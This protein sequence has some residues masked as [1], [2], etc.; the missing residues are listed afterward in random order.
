MT[1]T[2]TTTTTTPTRSNFV[3]RS[4]PFRR[5]SKWAFGVCDKDGD[6]KIEQSELY[7]GILLVH[8]NLA[9]YG[10]AACCYPPAR[11]VVDQL[12]LAADADQSGTID[13]SEFSDI[14][15]ICF[16]DIAG[17][18]VVYYGILILLVPYVADVIVAV[19][20]QLDSWMG[21]QLEGLRENALLRFME[22]FMT[23]KEFADSC[24]SMSLFF[25]VIP[26]LFN[27]IDRH[28]KGHAEKTK[29]P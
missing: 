24:V 10:G 5:L 14:V 20:F 21:W 29:S 17:R 25:F 3:T 16:V 4:A 22:N 15:Q 27:A 9:K 13:E 19:L 12:F 2:A 18:I 6:G 11:E 8:V 1:A 23:W 26:M 7:A 28:S